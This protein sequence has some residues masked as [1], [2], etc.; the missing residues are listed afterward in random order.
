MR[1]EFSVSQN[2]EFDQTISLR[3]A[4]FSTMDEGGVRRDR[5]GATTSRAPRLLGGYA[6]PEQR[7][8]GVMI[9]LLLVLLGIAPSALVAS[10]LPCD[11]FAAASP[12]VAAHSVT[13]ALC[14]PQSIIV[15]L[16]L[17]AA[18]PHARVRVRDRLSGLTA[19]HDG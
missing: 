13:R 7:A 15:L 19:L 12:C 9:L 3:G 1:A 11:I 5:R 10:Q 16:H 2:Q 17:A 4:F 8:R 18:R 6:R 14:T